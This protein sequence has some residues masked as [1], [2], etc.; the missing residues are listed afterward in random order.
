MSVC[1][2]EMPHFSL[3]FQLYTAHQEVPSKLKDTENC[4]EN[5]CIFPHN[6]FK[7]KNIHVLVKQSGKRISN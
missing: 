1:I 7:G 3:H 5:I 6:F 2:T 4:I